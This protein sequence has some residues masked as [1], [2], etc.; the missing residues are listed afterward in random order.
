[1]QS[2]PDLL[3]RVR[4]A[5]LPVRY[6]FLSR[7][8]QL[9]RDCLRA[10]A[11]WPLPASR[12]AVADDWLA[13]ATGPGPAGWTPMTHIN[14]G[15][16]TPQAF[17]ARFVVDPPEPT[18]AQLPKR[19]AAPPL[20]AGIPGANARTCVDVQDSYARLYNEGEMA[21][22]RA[23]PAASDDLAVW[24]PGSHH[25]WATQFPFAG[26]P[27][28]VRQGKWHIYALIRVEK[29]ADASGDAP[30]FTAGIYDSAANVGRG[31]ISIS[32]KDAGD[33]YAPYLLGTVESNKDE[34]VWIAPTAN[35]GVKAVWVDRLYFVPAN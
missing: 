27:P 13:T 17:V 30:A 20:P 5:H 11:T 15:G 35:P 8:P 10:G 12:K 23:D 34:Y 33:T 3:W 29:A 21:E 25:E 32:I 7:W 9:R 26:L 24:M 22:V 16:T 18:Q 6:V 1:V 19:K 2:S 31:Q 4:Q 14:E 28:R